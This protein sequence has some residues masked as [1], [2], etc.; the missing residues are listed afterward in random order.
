MQG[1]AFKMP[2]ALQ[3]DAQIWF[4]ETRQRSPNALNT[5]LAEHKWLEILFIFIKL[6]LSNTGKYRY[7]LQGQLLII[8][9]H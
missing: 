2:M 3:V 5:R 9:S 6:V 1:S 8:H 4:L 7:K